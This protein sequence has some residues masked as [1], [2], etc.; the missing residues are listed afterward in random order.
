M[1]VVGLR[2]EECPIFMEHDLCI[3]TVL[4]QATSST[5]NMAD[6]ELMASIPI[7]RCLCYDSDL[8]LLGDRLH[9]LIIAE[10]LCPCKVSHANWGGDAQC[11]NY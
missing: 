10:G 5:S 1:A 8:C 11:I 3:H 7:G 6:R 9:R 4:L 2:V